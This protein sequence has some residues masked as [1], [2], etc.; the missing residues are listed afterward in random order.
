MIWIS[1]K[2]KKEELVDGSNF[3]MICII[4]KGREWKQMIFIMSNLWMIIGP[5]NQAYGDF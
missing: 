2:Y 1:V 4:G 5:F 3:D